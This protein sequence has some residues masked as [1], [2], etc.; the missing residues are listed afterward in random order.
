MGVRLRMHAV[1]PIWGAA[2]IAAASFGGRHRAGS[3]AIA[4]AAFALAATWRE[5]MKGLACDRSADDGSLGVVWPLGGLTAVGRRGERGVAKEWWGLIGGVGWTGFWALAVWV[6]NFGPLVFHPFDPIGAVNATT[7]TPGLVVWWLYVAGVCVTLCN[8]VI[9]MVPF[10]LGRLLWRDP[11]GERAHGEARVGYVASM[12]L[13]VAA[14]AMGHT[15]LMAVA[16]IGA[17]VTYLDGR[18][19]AGVEMQQSGREWGREPGLGGVRRGMAGPLPEGDVIDGEP[20][21]PTLDDVLEKISR[22]GLASL[23]ERERGV[24]E[25]ERRRRLS[26]GRNGPDRA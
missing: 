5:F 3:A 18:R 15:R 11:S 12:T 7:L 22:D 24:L 14:A 21:T 16:A 20:E 4:V 10:D 9:P 6:G 19:V 25:A 13:F 23:S 17:L 2:E 26:G 8:A 1:M